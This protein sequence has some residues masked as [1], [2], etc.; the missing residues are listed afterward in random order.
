[1]EL[2]SQAGE[3]LCGA[4]DLGG[5]AN[6][7]QQ[8]LQKQRGEQLRG[9]ASSAASAWQEVQVQQLLAAA[10]TYQQGAMAEGMQAAAAA[11]VKKAVAATASSNAAKPLSQ[12][13]A[14]QRWSAQV[15]KQLEGLTAE[16]QRSMPPPLQPAQQ[17]AMGTMLQRHAA[18]VAVQKRASP[19]ALEPVLTAILQQV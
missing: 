3:V 8:Q 1:M 5:A 7:Q 13:E 6:W 19:D 16:R 10:D 18:C 11:A 9:C 12:E 17:V 4:G 15:E 14:R 2:R